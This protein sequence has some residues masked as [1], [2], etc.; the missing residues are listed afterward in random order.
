MPIAAEHVHP[1]PAERGANRAA[2]AYAETL[3]HVGDFDLVLLELGADGH[4]AGL[5]PEHDQSSGVQT[6]DTLAV[7]DAPKPFEQRV[8]MSARRL[9]HARAVLFLVEGESKRHA[10]MRWRSGSPIA[11]RCIQP[12]AGIDILLE[13]RLLGG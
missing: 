8:S 10:I 9:S 13:A 1:I 5:F 11:A 4:T 3:R 2:L 12:T 6:V 7:F